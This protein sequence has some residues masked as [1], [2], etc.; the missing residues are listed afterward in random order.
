M[1]FAERRI[2]HIKLNFSVRVKNPWFRV[3]V[4]AT[5]LTAIGVDPQTFTSWSAVCEG[6]LT[7]LG[8]PVQLVTLVLAVLGVFIDP[9]TAGIA[10]SKRALNYTKPA[11]EDDYNGNAG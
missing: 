5:A 4:A 6:I 7:L 1:P 9:T 11:K 2:I 8:N 10:D 3:G